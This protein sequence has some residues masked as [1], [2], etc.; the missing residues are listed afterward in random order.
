MG[1]NK[2]HATLLKVSYCDTTMVGMSATSEQTAACYLTALKELLKRRGVTYADLAEAL[3]CSLPTIKRSLN[4]T[5]LPLERLLEIA[6]VANLDFAEIHK[7][8]EQLRPQHYFFTKE[9]DALFAKQPE[10]LAYLEELL[11]G[12]TPVEISRHHDL[13]VQSTSHYQKRL[14]EVGLIKRKQRRQVKLLVRPPVGFGP[15]SLYLKREMQSFLE[16]VVTE[17]VNAEGSQPGL[18]AILKPLSLTDEEFRALV[19]NLKRIVDQ[20][21]AIGENRTAAGKATPRQMAIACGPG[22]RQERRR[23][24]RVTKQ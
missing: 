12:K 11:D 13:D 1:V 7:R 24:P 22:H 2:R 3:R 18:F 21:S 20:Y 9:Q 23:L 4:K 10:T 5:S 17:V 6:E 8:A 14:E 16:S 19:D 15:G